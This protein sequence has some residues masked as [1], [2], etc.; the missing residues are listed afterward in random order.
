MNKIY[1][2]ARIST[3][4]Q[5]IDR[6]IKNLDK[7]HNGIEIYQ[8][9]FSGTS[10]D[11]PNWKKLQKRL[12]EGDTLVFDSVSRMS[13]NS[14]EGSKKYFELLGKGV[15][16]IFL[17]EPYINTEVYNNTLKSSKNISV[18]DTDLN[19]TILQGVREYMNRLAKKQIAIAFDQA[20][21]EVEDMRLR[22]KEGLKVAKSKGIQ[23]GRPRGA[24][25]I[26]KR[27]KYLKEKLQSHS[28]A[29]G[30]TMTDKDFIEAYKCSKSTLVKYKRELKIELTI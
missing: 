16:L 13:R 8:E 27:E 24:K 15:T 30:G 4:K 14:E 11:R 18:A 26:T 1:G 2:Y 10:K 9:V 23:L 20:E 3:A 7:F 5:S 28:K 21:K 6:Q 22:T 12:K 25:S 19:D 29:F 17:K